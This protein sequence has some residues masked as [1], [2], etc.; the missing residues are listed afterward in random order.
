VRAEG[1]DKRRGNV[2]GGKKE[3]KGALKYFYKRRGKF[4]VT[5]LYNMS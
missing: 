3:G 2:K 5:P 1:K 4:E